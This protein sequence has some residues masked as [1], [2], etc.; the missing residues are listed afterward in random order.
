MAQSWY[1]MLMVRCL[2]AV[3]W[4]QLLIYFFADAL[5]LRQELR[6]VGKLIGTYPGQ[7]Y[8]VNQ[9]GLPL[10]LLNEEAKLLIE[11]GVCDLVEMVYLKDPSQ[12]KIYQQHI[13]KLGKECQEIVQSRK[14][15]MLRLNIDEIE[16]T[17]RE[18]LIKKRLESDISNKES[19]PLQIFIKYPWN[20]T[21]NVMNNRWAYPVDKREVIKY[22]V[23]KD[24]WKA[25]YY[26]TCGLQFGCD[27]LVY[28]GDP[29]ALH[30]RY[31][32]LCK[33]NDEDMSAL[34]FVALS[35][36]AVQA[37]KQLII[38]SAPLEH[39]LSSDQSDYTFNPIYLAFTW[40]GNHDS[41]FKRTL[42]KL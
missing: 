17:K 11:E 23:F 33:N 21:Y 16:E 27:Y 10:C 14:E 31:M 37:N 35:R 20:N 2:I 3:C 8:Q 24:L 29:V 12:S 7:V 25:G 32:V 9:H 22:F 39:S 28:E 1:G 26:I 13:D 4:F 34:Q 6:I 38:A 36:V 40:R 5:R 19:F 42:M 15:K 41:P 30:A 18:E